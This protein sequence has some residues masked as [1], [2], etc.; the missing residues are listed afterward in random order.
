MTNGGTLQCH[1]LH[2]P[3][4]IEYI[5][6]YEYYH[7]VGVVTG[8]SHVSTTYMGGLVCHNDS[9]NLLPKKSIYL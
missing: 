6:I 1:T 3:T 2:G 8:E 4:T 7:T 9:P 5:A